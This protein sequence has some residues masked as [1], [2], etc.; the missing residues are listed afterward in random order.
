MNSSK[1]QLNITTAKH[2]N[3]NTNAQLH[4]Q[5]NPKQTTWKHTKRQTDTPNKQHQYKHDIPNIKIHK[6]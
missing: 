4:K 5:N 1:Q 2:N 3:T 6:T